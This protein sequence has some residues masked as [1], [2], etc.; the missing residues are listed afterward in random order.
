MTDSPARATKRAKTD[1]ANG[2]TQ[3]DD[4]LFNDFGEYDKVCDVWVFSCM[5]SIH[6]DTLVTQEFKD[7]NNQ[8]AT[9]Q[10]TNAST[11]GAW[12]IQMNENLAGY[13]KHV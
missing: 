6:I 1:S 5:Y 9:Q 7:V 8:N 10:Q 4:D 3:G 12:S 2:N 13:F 11:G